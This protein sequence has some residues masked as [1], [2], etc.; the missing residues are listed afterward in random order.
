MNIQPD[1]E[2]LS[3]SET[4]SSIVNKL[5]ASGWQFLSMMPNIWDISDDYRRFIKSAHNRFENNFPG[6]TEEIR[7]LGTSSLK[8]IEDSELPALFVLARKLY[9]IIGNPI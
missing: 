2:A 7:M 1:W 9:A 4:P 3:K 5:N 8:N 6:T